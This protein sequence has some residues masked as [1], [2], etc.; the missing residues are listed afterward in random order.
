MTCDDPKK[1]FF[2]TFDYSQDAL[3]E[4]DAFFRKTGN[5]IVALTVREILEEQFAKR[6]A[7]RGHCPRTTV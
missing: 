4:I 7:E 2:V 3:I 1:G 6:L 5:V